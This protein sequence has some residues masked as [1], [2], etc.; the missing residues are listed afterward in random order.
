MLG[1]AAVI[2]WF[3]PVGLLLPYLYE[4]LSKS[5]SLSCSI[6]KMIDI[7]ICMTMLSSRL[8]CTYVFAGMSK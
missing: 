1:H 2:A 5:L 7:D 6:M 8:W 3:N 4:F